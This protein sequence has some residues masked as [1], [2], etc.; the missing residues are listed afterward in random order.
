[1]NKDQQ[2]SCSGQKDYEQLTLDL[3]GGAAEVAELHEGA[4]EM[5]KGLRERPW[6]WCLESSGET[7][8]NPPWH[9]PQR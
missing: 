3:N 8:E 4:Q 1:M 6:R 2:A 7:S 5:L 9:F